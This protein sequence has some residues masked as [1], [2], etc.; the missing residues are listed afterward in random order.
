MR[1]ASPKKVEK[2]CGV[3]AGVRRFFSR[4][5]PSGAEMCGQSHTRPKQARAEKEF[6]FLL[7]GERQA[8]NRFIKGRGIKTTPEQNPALALPQGARDRGGGGAWSGRG[9]YSA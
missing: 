1:I 6:R 3:G 4:V 2:R 5:N 8:C 9:R 7:F